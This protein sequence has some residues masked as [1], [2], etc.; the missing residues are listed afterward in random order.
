MNVLSLLSGI[1]AWVLGLTAIVRRGCRLC[2]GLS[3]SCCGSALFFQLLQV[4]RLAALR[5]WSALEDTIAAVVFAAGVL[6][7]VTVL[8]N[9]L[10]LLRKPR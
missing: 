8:L 10:A 3:Y 4:Q 2:S 1:L 5:D 7:G 6:L 9:F